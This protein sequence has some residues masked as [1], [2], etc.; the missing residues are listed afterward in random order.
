MSK[1]QRAIQEKRRIAD[2][3]GR[4]PVLSELYESPEQY[5]EALGRIDAEVEEDYLDGFL[6]GK[7]D[8][9]SI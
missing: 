3:W 1:H 5:A 8:Q 2:H 4:Y 6:K 9:R 7:N